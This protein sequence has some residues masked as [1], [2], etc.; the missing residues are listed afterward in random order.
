M[1]AV[2]E[3]GGKQYRVAPGQTVEVERIPGEVGAEIELD[4]VL[5]FSPAPGTLLTGDELA[6]VRVRATIAA[7]FRGEK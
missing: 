6:G 1:Y 3:T 7:H 5:A 2:I 4:R